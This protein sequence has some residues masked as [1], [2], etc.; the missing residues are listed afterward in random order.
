V[1]TGQDLSD[2]GIADPG[3]ALRGVS[4]LQEGTIAKIK[5]SAVDIGATVIDPNGNGPTCL[6]IIDQETRSKGQGRMCSG[7]PVPIES[8]PVCGSTTME[9]VTVA[10]KRSY[11]AL[12]VDRLSWSE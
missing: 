2:S 6:R 9:T 8:F 3:D 7:N 12:P 11:G 5:P 1:S 10:V 4:H